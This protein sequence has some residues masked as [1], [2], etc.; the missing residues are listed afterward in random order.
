[1]GKY[2]MNSQETLKNHLGYT[3]W[4]GDFKALLAANK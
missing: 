1:M 4:S 3:A 2:N